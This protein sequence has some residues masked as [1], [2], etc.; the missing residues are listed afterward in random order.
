MIAGGSAAASAASHGVG[1]GRTAATIIGALGGATSATTEF[2]TVTVWEIG[3]KYDNGTWGTIRQT[4][5][6]P[7]RIGDRVLVTDQGLEY[8]R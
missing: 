5:S 1:S 8:L 7:F 6:P 3:V 2:Q 4:A